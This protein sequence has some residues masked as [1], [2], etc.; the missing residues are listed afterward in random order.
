MRHVTPPA[1]RWL[2][3]IGLATVPLLARPQLVIS[4]TLSGASSS[5]NWVSIGGAC[6]TAGNNTGS[7][8]ACVGLSYYSGTTLVGGVTG[9][10]TGSGD[11]VGQGALRLTNGDTTTGYNGNNQTGAI[12]SG[13]TFPTSQ[14][15]QVTWTS[16][17]YGGNAYGNPGGGASGADGVSFFL[18]N[19]DAAGSNFTSTMT[20]AGGLGGSLG[21]SCSNGNSQ[22]EGMPYGYLGVGI[23][24]YGNFS[25]PGDNT[26]TGPGTGP[27][28]GQVGVRGAGNITWA[29]LNAAKPTYYPSSLSSSNQTAAVRNTCSTGTYWNYSGSTKTDANGHS[30]SNQHATTE[31]VMDYPYITSVAFPTGTALYNQEATNMPTR[32][33]AIPITYTLSINSL[34]IL[35][36]G[37]SINGGASNPVLTNLNIT[38]NNGALPNNFYFGFSAGTGGGSNVHEILC[39]KATQSQ[40]SESSTGLNQNPAN[41]INTGTQVYTATYHPTNWWGQ[42]QANNVVVNSTTGVASIASTSNWD[43]SCVLT[44]GACTSTGAT[45]GTAQTSA[46]R[47][48]LTY[49]QSAG[50]ALQWGNLSTAQQTALDSSSVGGS[51]STRL[52]FLRGDRSNEVNNGG[53]FRNRTSVLGD[54]IDASP[55]W[56]GPPSLPYNGPLI[57]TLYNTALTEADSYN[58]FITSYQTRTNVVYVGSNDGLLHGFRAG[59]YNTA[60]YYDTTSTNDGKELIAYMPDAVVRSIHTSNALLDYSSPS[61]THN[62]YVNAQS[63]TGDLYYNGAWHSWLVSGLGGG[64]NATGVIGNNTTAGSGSIFALDVTNPGNFSE[65]NASTLVIGEWNNSNLSCVTDT[66]TVK[67]KN[68]LGNTY[69]TPIIRRLH[70]GNWAVIFGNGRNNSTGR[71]GVYIL[72][73]ANATGN[74]SVRFLDTGYTP[75]GSFLNGIS[76][77]SSADLDGDHVTDY[78]YAGDMAGNVWRF[79]LTSQTASQWAVRSQPIFQT[80]GLPITSHITVAL[81]PVGTQTRLMLDFGTGEIFPQTLTTAETPASTS[82]QYLFGIWDW[83]MSAWNTLAAGAPYVSLARNATGVPST[84]TVT[85]SMLQT[86]TITTYS[87]YSSGNISGVRTLTNNKVCWNNSTT[88]TPSTANTQFGWQIAL[89][90]GT[91]SNPEQLIYNPTL[92]YGLVLFDT[93]IPGVPQVLSCTAQL[94]TGYTMAMQPDTGGATSVSFFGSA[95]SNYVTANGQ[96]ISGVGLGAVGSV[97]FVTSSNVP[98]IIASDAAGNKKILPVN[99]NAA[100]KGKRLTWR[101]LR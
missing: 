28:Q 21:Y 22:Y 82:T 26:A 98:Y 43:G 3:C 13:F 17:T 29:A 34:G 74:I 90:G 32:G 92:Q 78:L 100:G 46:N 6:L 60:G 55:V 24:E 23:D 25:N 1:L 80:G 7:I 72:E 16:A 64:G 36:L 83:D 89:T 86:Q 76:Y 49:N 50:A 65:S 79:D 96:V 40:E 9:R 58:G 41:Q 75:S 62:Q 88:C 68:Y 4:D 61:Y 5:Y 10:L 33:A 51:S 52:N 70:D 84:Y 94:P 66:T 27:Q 56:V 87:S 101:K 59:A 73:V 38:T 39:F 2:A 30:I 12:V 67:C 19:A 47:S 77:V 44:G 15:V 81:V 57:D 69:G 48:I 11:P 18:L 54:V 63:G 42:L 37:Y 45:S 35:N 8:P 97:S 14:G 95:T 93:T 20:K 71:A 31:T 91:S 53:S 85:T 99:T